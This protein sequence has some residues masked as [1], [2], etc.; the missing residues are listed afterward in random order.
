MN[1]YSATSDPVQAITLRVGIFFD[2]TGNNR[3][4]SVET[5]GVPADGLESL[6]DT[7][8]GNALTNVALLHECYQETV[9]RLG[10]GDARAFLK[11]YVEGIGTTQGQAD[12]PYAQATGR[13]RTGVMA[14]V[15]HAVEA[16]AGQLAA[17]LA[18]HPQVRIRA[19]EFDLFGFSRGAAAA[20]HLANDLLKGDDSLLAKAIASKPQVF[21]EAFKGSAGMLINFIGLF[22]TVAAII[23]PLSGD[24]SASNDRNDGLDLHLGPDAA[25]KVV[26]LVAADEHRHNFP[27]VHTDHDIPV[28]GAHSDIGGGYLERMQ[29]RVLLSKPR[30]NRVPAGTPVQRTTAHAAAEALL[31]SEYADS[32]PPRPRVLTWEVPL[33]EDRCKRQGPEKQVYATLFRE[34][35][36]HGHLSRVYLRIMR[37]LAVGCG[38]PLTE[39]DQAAERY[40]LP[41]DLQG[42][43]QKLQDFALGRSPAPNLTDEEQHLLRAKYIH[44]SAHWNPLKGLRNS[45][46][47]LFYINRPAEGGRMVHG[48]VTV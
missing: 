22:D 38:V 42:I 30:S 12:S 25:R 18:S 48:K 10:E 41:Q 46:L 9:G 26:Q 16:C 43:G 29:E 14:R 35:E 40:C 20:R 36:V 45:A 23:S 21:A 8:Y 47:D 37:E 2:G 3:S 32:P 24:F 31:A 13:W 6:S 5:S 33:A 11:V 19:V 7:S 27:L 39:L 17:M 34:R 4:N 28:P 15:V 1:M 44:T